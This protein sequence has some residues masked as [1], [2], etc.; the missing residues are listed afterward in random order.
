MSAEFQNREPELT[1]RTVNPGAEKWLGEVVP[2]LD[3]GFI[4]LVDYMGDD[5]SIAQAARVSYG[6]GTKSVSQTEGL[7]RYLDR[8]RHTSPFE[9]SE[10]KFHVKLPISV[11]RQ[12]V[13][14]RTASLNEY[15]ARY[16][17]LKDEFYIPGADSVNIQSANN[18]QG[19]GDGVGKD[20]A[21]FVRRVFEENGARSYADY[22]LLLNDDG[23]GNPVDPRRPQIARELARNVLPVDI[24]T[25]WYWK[26]DLHNLFHFLALRMD[27]HAQL[28]IRQYANVMATIVKDAFPMSYKAFEDYELFATALSRPEQ[29]TLSKLLLDSGLT[30]TA[31]QVD[32]A[33]KVVGL[34]N[35]REREELMEKLTKLG[36]VKK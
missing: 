15:S 34:T 20:E 17:I 1:K 33:S 8:N 25:Q 11:A 22:Q 2:V 35:K 32:Q 12:W 26:V 13:R 10:L 6:Y 3:H 31:D 21:E 9:M 27:P 7:I 4:Y 36:I 30:F 29:N 28:E 23:T 16:S 5:E 19:R 18:K 14:H 24:Y